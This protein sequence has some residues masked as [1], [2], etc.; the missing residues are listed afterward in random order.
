MNEGSGDTTP[1][2]TEHL[3]A[4]GLPRRRR[5]TDGERRYRESTKAIVPRVHVVQTRPST[6]TDHRTHQPAF[7]RP[8]VD[9]W[10][11][12]YQATRRLSD[13]APA[14][15]ALMGYDPDRVTEEDYPWSV[16]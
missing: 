15:T 13:R 12:T 3:E 1:A 9:E 10:R 14:A 5:D 2:V 7:N 8:T 16:P 6:P 4:F 11:P